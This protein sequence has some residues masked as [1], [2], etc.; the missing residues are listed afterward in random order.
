MG[1]LLCF[2]LCCQAVIPLKYTINSM[3]EGD[4]EDQSSG[5]K[6]Y[7]KDKERNRLFNEFLS[8]VYTP[9]LEFYTIS[10]MNCSKL[11]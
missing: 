9:S 2:L 3:R 4:E 7:I 11:S 1:F 10:G 5:W 6:T 8:K